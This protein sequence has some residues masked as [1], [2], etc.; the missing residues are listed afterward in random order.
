MTTRP[1]L[2]RLPKG[3]DRPALGR[4]HRTANSWRA[5]CWCGWQAEAACTEMQTAYGAG[6]QHVADQA[7]VCD[8]TEA[9]IRCET[10]FR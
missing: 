2:R 1:Q 4:G 7:P 3:R 5:V 6:E 8:E 9:W 10:A